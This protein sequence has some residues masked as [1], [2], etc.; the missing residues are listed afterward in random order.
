MRLSIF[1]MASAFSYLVSLFFGLGEFAKVFT[2][3]RIDDPTDRFRAAFIAWG[4]ESLASTL[5]P[6]MLRYFLLVQFLLIGFRFYAH[7]EAIDANAKFINDKETTFG[8]F[9]RFLWVAPAVLL[10][11]AL[12][13]VPASD[14]AGA[15]KLLVG[16][17]WV[18]TLMYLTMFVWSILY[19]DTWIE[20]RGNE[21]AMTPRKRRIL[22]SSEG[23]LLFTLLICAS[24]STFTPVLGL[25][26]I[27]VA[28]CAAVCALM[29][30]VS[31]VIFYGGRGSRW[32]MWAWAMLFVMIIMTLVTAFRVLAAL[33]AQI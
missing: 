1:S 3:V 17:P 31:C 9:L 28:I 6:D 7:A 5:G 16:V 19:F 20:C 25:A 8:R 29:V 23:M 12:A 24:L 32:N 21:T 18:L 11:I 15:A 33:A 30:S 27:F 26:S 22:E 10:P 13:F 2:V 4:N 14:M